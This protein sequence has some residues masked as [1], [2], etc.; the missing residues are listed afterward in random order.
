MTKKEL[1][2]E[3][4]SICDALKIAIAM[5]KEAN[6]VTHGGKLVTVTPVG[7]VYTSFSLEL[8]TAFKAIDLFNALNGCDKPFTISED[9]LNSQLNV[10]WGRKRA[11]I[12][13][14]PKV[15]IYAPPIDAIQNDKIGDNFKKDLND[16]VSDLISRANDVA[17]SVVAFDGYEAFWTNRQIAAKTT[18]TTWLPPLYA[19][20]ND[21]KAVTSLNGNIIGIGGTAHSIT[22]HFDTDTAVQIALADDSINYPLGALKGLFRP[23]LFDAKYELTAEFIDGLNY[24]AKFTDDVIYVSPEHV[25]TDENPSLGTAVEQKDIPLSLLFYGTTIKLGAFKGADSIIKLSD[26]KSSIG[27]YTMKKNCIF[28]FVRIRP[29]TV[30]A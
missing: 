29:T 2:S 16:F 20:V 1:N 18:F 13:T 14:M 21:L 28:A 5:E 6:C 19:F 23:D 27:F 9:P 30:T 10:S 4:L 15:S 22:F 12:K 7:T 25:G 17:S 3:A 24:V 8:N 11:K 26:D